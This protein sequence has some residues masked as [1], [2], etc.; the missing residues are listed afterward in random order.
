MRNT[1]R[2]AGQKLQSGPFCV[3]IS[4]MKARV[5]VCTKSYLFATGL[6][7]LAS[8]YPLKPRK[9]TI[10][11]HFTTYLSSDM[12]IKQQKQSPRG[13]RSASSGTVFC[14]S[15]VSAKTCFPGRRTLLLL[16]RPLSRKAE[17][18]FNSAISY[19][20]SIMCKAKM[21]VGSIRIQIYGPGK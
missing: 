21:A 7:E 1:C 14:L 6:H 10:F 8:K 17:L 20:K 4:P 18:S 19:S 12:T 15:A 9:T 13:N 11:S 2:N 3:T 5:F 16:C